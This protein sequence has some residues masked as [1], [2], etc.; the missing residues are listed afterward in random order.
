M[1]SQGRMRYPL[2]S[3]RSRVERQMV[4]AK[5]LAAPHG[6]CGWTCGLAYVCGAFMAGFGLIYSLRFT[7]YSFSFSDAFNSILFFLLGL[8]VFYISSHDSFIAKKMYKIGYDVK[9]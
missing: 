6:F 9:S 7:F 1:R 3:V 5:T 2:A 8:I 4:K